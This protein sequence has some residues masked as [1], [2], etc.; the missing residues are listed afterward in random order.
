MKSR[1]CDSYP[2][3]GFW[4]C[5]YCRKNLNSVSENTWGGAGIFLRWKIAKGIA[6]TIPFMSTPARPN[7][8]SQVT[9]QLNPF[10][11]NEQ[12]RQL[13][14]SSRLNLFSRFIMYRLLPYH[15]SLYDNRGDIDW[16]LTLQMKH[17]ILRNH[18]LICV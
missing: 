18:P 3:Q 12:C 9:S 6:P 2:S 13:L 17:Y 10:R 8:L 4:C 7:I 5:D 11:K 16:K 1:L 14:Q 15:W